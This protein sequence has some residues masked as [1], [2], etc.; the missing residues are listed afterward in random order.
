MT[1]QNKSRKRS[2]DKGIAALII[3]ALGAGGIVALYFL[4]PGFQFIDLA[5]LLVVVIFTASGYRQG[6]IR[7]LMTIV[8]LYFATGI[9][10]TLY[11]VPAPYVAGIG[12]LFGFIFAGQVMEGDMAASTQTVSGDSLAI[13]F[14]LL[15]LV[16]WIVLEAIGRSTFQDTSLPKLGILDKFGGIVVHFVIGALV[17][18]LLFNAIGYGHLRRAHNKALLR[19]RFNQ[20]LSL[21]YTTQSFWFGSQPPPI[22]VY[23][24]DVMREP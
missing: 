10:A 21:H 22:Y 1:V 15:T 24:L 3:A 11:P 20:I 14:M 16:I 8:I 13:S 9:A 4:V 23:D 19:T 6:T 2:D 7:G 5:M 17:A 12:K 18:S